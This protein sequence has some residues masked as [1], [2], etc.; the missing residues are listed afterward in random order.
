MDVGFHGAKRPAIEHF[1][2]GGGDAARGDVHHGF[3]GVVE[4]LENCQQSFHGFRQAREFHGDFGD[5]RERAF[6]ADEQ[7]QQIVAGRIERGAADADQFAG[8]QNDFERENVIGGD[9]V[10]E[11]VR[12]AGIFGNVAADGAGFL[13]GRIGRKMQSGVGDGGAEIGI[14]Y[15]GLDGGALI[16]DINFQNAIHARKNCEDAALARKRAAGKAGAGAAPDQR[17]LISIREFDDAEDIGGRARKDDAVRPR[18]FDRAVVF[19]KQ[20]LLG[21]V[22]DAVGA[23][24]RFQVVEKSGIHF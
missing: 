13:A 9:A 20:Q 6:G 10:R 12:A 18:D 5:Q 4:S 22:Q 15:A 17:N 11:G 16:F 21:P 3:G 8:G 23:E 2:G 7:T 1:A 14:H 24:K 19:V